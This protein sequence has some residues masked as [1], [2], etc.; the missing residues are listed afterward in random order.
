MCF[1]T[2]TNQTSEAGEGRLSNPRLAKDGTSR[3]V[4]C[5]Q[6]F[7]RVHTSKWPADS[8]RRQ[9]IPKTHFSLF[10]DLVLQDTVLR[11]SLI[12]NLG[13]D[14]FNILVLSDLFPHEN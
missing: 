9:F 1:N 12:H 11:W 4:S 5:R 6:C 14:Y 3:L 10:S 2:Q 8:R 13:A 7:V